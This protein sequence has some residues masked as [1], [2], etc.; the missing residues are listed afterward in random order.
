MTSILVMAAALSVVS[1]SGTDAVDQPEIH[2]VAKLRDESLVVGKVESVEF[3][4]DCVLG[5]VQV[6]VECV[7]GVEMQDDGETATITTWKDDQL[8]GHFD[9]GALRGHP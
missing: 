5:R 4:F 1:C 6:S 7:S 3:P 8:N 9:F 2:L